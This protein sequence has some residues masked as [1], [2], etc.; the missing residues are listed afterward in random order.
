MVGAGFEVG[1]DIAPRER[2]RTGVDGGVVGGQHKAPPEH[3]VHL[4]ADDLALVA[5]REH[6][7]MEDVFG[8][9]DLGSLVAF[10]DVFDNQVMQPEHGAQALERL[11]PGIDHV[12]PQPGIRP[13]IG[14]F[15]LF[16]GGQHALSLCIRPRYGP[17]QRALA[18]RPVRRH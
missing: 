3:N 5:Q 15:D 14:S 7:Q 9:L 17:D 18:R 4:M 8:Q 6:D 2:R 10:E 11:V 16:E 13:L 12:D 1:T